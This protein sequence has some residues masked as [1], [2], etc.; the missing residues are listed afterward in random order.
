MVKLAG[1]D[2]TIIFRK[3]VEQLRAFYDTLEE[4]KA[5]ARSAD[6]QQQGIELRCVNCI[7]RDTHNQLPQ[8]LWNLCN[9][10][11]EW[12]TMPESKDSEAREEKMLIIKL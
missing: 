10:R 8:R 9:I 6:Q 3:S 4:Q 2:V 11:K 1:E 12:C 7:L 5:L